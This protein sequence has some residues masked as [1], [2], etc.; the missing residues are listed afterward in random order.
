MKQT[1][2][3]LTGV[4]APGTW[5][6]VHSLKQGSFGETI[7][8]TGIDLNP[9]AVGKVWCN[10]FYLAP[11]T[12]NIETYINELLNIVQK[13][14]ITFILPQTTLETAAL[15]QHKTAFEAVNC[16]VLTSHADSI[17]KANDKYEVLKIAEANGIPVPRYELVKDLNAL[18]KAIH[19]LGYPTHKVVVKPRHGNGGRGV[20]IITAEPPSIHK[21]LNQK[22]DSMDTCLDR[23]LEIFE[24]N[25]LEA[26][27]ELLVSEYLPGEEYTI[28]ALKT[29]AQTIIIPRHRRVIRSGISFE[30]VV[31]MQQKA[32]VQHSETLAEVLD[33]A[34]CFG[35]QFKLDA[36]GIPKLLECNPRVQ[37][38]MVA[39]TFA[40][41]N[42]IQAAVSGEVLDA[43]NIKDGSV[44]SRY[45]GG[46]GM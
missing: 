31:D 29:E 43:K 23:F 44:F 41:A 7:K 15:S 42:I 2:I 46:V 26:F 13:E 16:T 18:K 37:G 45:W 17:T 34:H 4:G 33:L 35:F 28:D 27:P 11:S 40:G 12:K 32:M 6:T 20:R 19:N 25:T 21:Y 24:N 30:T 22:P 1:N 9:E 8:I 39:S 14:L 38:T 3:L 10:A 5:G 36:A